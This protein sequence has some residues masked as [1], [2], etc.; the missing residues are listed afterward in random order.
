[1]RVHA[2]MRHE[3]PNRDPL[4]VTVGDQVTVGERDT[5][6]PEFVF[7]SALHGEGWVP[8]RYLTAESGPATVVAP[9]DTTELAVQPGEELE[10]LVRDDPSGWWWCRSDSGDEGWVPV[11]VLAVPDEPL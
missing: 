6:W 10:V 11:A 3:R 4:R 2:E 9:Y 7:V 5:Q 1:M 8:A